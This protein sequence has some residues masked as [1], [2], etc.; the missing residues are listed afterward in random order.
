[1]VSLRLS[2]SLHREDKRK[3]EYLENEKG[4]CAGEEVLPKDLP[5]ASLTSPF[6]LYE[7][8]EMLM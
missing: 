6:P 5:P 7:L 1:V 8:R 2:T 4:A 3:K